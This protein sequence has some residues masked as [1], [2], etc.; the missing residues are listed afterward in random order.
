MS[1]VET[2][3]FDAWLDSAIIEWRRRCHRALNVP[4][5]DAE[6]IVEDVL[7]EL[8]RDVEAGKIDVTDDAAVK[9][10]M[11]RRITWRSTTYHKTRRSPGRGVPVETEVLAELPAQATGPEDACIEREDAEEAAKVAKVLHD[12]LAGLPPQQRRHAGLVASGLKP[13]ER[14]EALGMAPGTERVAW[15]RLKKRLEKMM[16][17]STSGEEEAV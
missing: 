9:G 13:K 12:I 10:Y 6:D 17:E 3:W 11:W 5:H 2:P 8:L 7:V 4:L 1:D 16:T 14:A 15:H